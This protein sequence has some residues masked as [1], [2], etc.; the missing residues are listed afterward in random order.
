MEQLSIVSFL[1]NGHSFHLYAYEQIEGVPK[2][3]TLKDAG[4]IIPPAKIFKYRHHDTYAGFS[5]LFRYRLLGEKGGYWVDTDVVCLRPFEF[6][7]QYMFASVPTGP[8]LLRW[9]KKYHIASWFLKAPQGSATMDY[10]YNEAARRDPRELAFGEIG[11][12]LITAAVEK[13]SM[14]RYVASPGTFCPIYAWQWKQL[15]NASFAA[16]RKWSMAL[17]SSYA[18]HLYHE[19]WR[20]NKV[21]KNDAFPPASIY[22]QLKRRYL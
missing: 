1:Q 15:I 14:Q 5:N 16:R 10:C 22:E 2:G 17:R 20:R 4:E 3:T 19:M 11:P 12:R 6:G 21:D 13:F 18:V 8:Q 7:A 9:K